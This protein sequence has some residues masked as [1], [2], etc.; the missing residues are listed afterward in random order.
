[1][2]VRKFCQQ[3]AKLKDLRKMT[4]WTIHSYGDIEELQ[5]E[6]TRIPIIRH[7]QD[8][9]VEVK[10]ASLNPIDSFMLGKSILYQVSGPFHYCCL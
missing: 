9:L 6:E 3:A 8:V 2:L 1:M 7:P 10:A 5:F 4:A